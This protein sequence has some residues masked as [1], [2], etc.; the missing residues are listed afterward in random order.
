[1]MR[2]TE[3]H[4]RRI[5]ADEVQKF[6]RGKKVNESMSAFISEKLN[7]AMDEYY[8]AM[9]GDVGHERALDELQNEVMWFIEEYR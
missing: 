3:S 8:T 5:I 7:D 1:M 2:I 4:L 9:A 6:K